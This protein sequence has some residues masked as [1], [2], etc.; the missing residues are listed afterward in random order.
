MSGIDEAVAAI[1]RGEIVVVMDDENRENEGD[2][3]CAAEKVTPEVVNFMIT[4]GRGLL[5]AP[6]LPEVCRRLDL[7]LMVDETTAP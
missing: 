5:C 3:I 2:F 7:P 6:V 1:A 4:R